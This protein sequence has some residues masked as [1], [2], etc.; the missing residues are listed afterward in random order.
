MRLPG[1]QAL[2]SLSTWASTDGQEHDIALYAVDWDNQGRSEQIQ[3]TSTG[4]GMVL[5]TETI[6]NFGGGVYLQWVVSG[7]VLVTVTRLTG[8]S[9]VLSGLF[10]DASQDAATL[11]NTDSTT[12]GSWIGGYGSQGYNVVGNASS[13]PNYAIV[14]PVGASTITWAASTTDSRALQD[15]GGTSRV[16][17]SWYSSASFI[18]DV[19]LTDNQ[20]HDISFYALDW[21]GNNSRSEQIQIGG[22]NNRGDTGHRDHLEIHA[23]VY[24]KWAVTGNVIITVTSLSG[25]NAVLSGLFFDPPLSAAS[26]AKQDGTTQGNWIGAYGNQGYNVVGNGASY[27]A[28]ATVKVSG[29]AIPRGLP[30][31]PIQELF[32]MR[33]GSAGLQP[34]GPREPVSR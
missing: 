28:Y 11:V 3:I 14:Q 9:A 21:D 30:A 5:D 19:D 25:A 18:V 31:R 16:A 13:N 27:P 8:P 12:K 23:G 32:R 33:A 34:P 7:N 20:E 29:E 22:A 1:L 26:L 15:V 24:L 2:A 10:M 6:T 4:T 17:A